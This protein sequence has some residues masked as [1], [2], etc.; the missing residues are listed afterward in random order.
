MTKLKKKNIQFP[1]HI[2][3]ITEELQLTSLNVLE[4]KTLAEVSQ[5]PPTTTKTDQ[6]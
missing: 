2:S 5:L 1:I 4:K 3:Q 6:E